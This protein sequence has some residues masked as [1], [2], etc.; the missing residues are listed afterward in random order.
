MTDLIDSRVAKF[1][2][3]PTLTGRE[4]RCSVNI[5]GHGQ[6]NQIDL[7]GHTGSLQ[8]RVISDLN[9]DEIKC[10]HKRF[11]NFQPRT[12][13]HDRHTM[14]QSQLFSR[15]IVL[16]FEG[17]RERFFYRFEVHL[18][19][20]DPMI[21]R[22]RLIAQA[23]RLR[24]DVEGPRREL[25]YS[26][27]PSVPETVPEQT[28]F[29]PKLVDLLK[30]SSTLISDAA[31]FSMWESWAWIFQIVVPSLVLV[32]L[33]PWGQR[34]RRRRSER[35]EDLVVTGVAVGLPG[36]KP[37]AAD[38][39]ASLVR[40]ECRIERLEPASVEALLEKRVVQLKKATGQKVAVT[41]P[42]QTVA[43]AG[44]LGRIDLD[45]YGVPKALAKTM[46]KASQAAVAA[47]LEALADAG[48]VGADWKL[49]SELQAST[50]VVYATSFPGLDAAV[51]E[52]ERYA[53]SL[54]KSNADL[55]SVLGDRL[56]DLDKD[57]ASDAKK[58]LDQLAALLLKEDCRKNCHHPPCACENP[59]HPPNGDSHHSGGEKKETY[60]F[61]R[62]F[63]FKVLVLGNSQL[64]QIT[65][66]KGPNAQTNAACA[67][68]TQ[69]M[70][71]AEDWLRAG[72][73]DRVVVI[74]GDDAS[75]D[76]LLPWLGGG[77]NA[78]GA[79]SVAASPKEAA[80]PFDARRNGMVLGAGAVGLVLEKR[81]AARKKSTC[82]LVATSVSNS[83]FHGAAMDRHH[84]SLE[85]GKF[86]EMVER[87]HGVSRSRI[88]KYGIYLSHETGTHATPS[89]SCAANEIFALKQN[90]HPSDLKH[91]LL[92]NTKAYTG[93]P[94]GVGVEDAFAAYAL[95]TPN[96]TCPPLPSDTVLDTAFDFPL[97]LPIG[98]K[99]RSFDFALRFAAG[100][101]SH[102]AFA[103]YART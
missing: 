55:V 38:N 42:R 39:F 60:T 69:A 99:T 67:G 20:V 103:L 47:G 33:L 8:G 48:L 84:I 35:K 98:K 75:G 71:I 18:G 15:T 3:G 7:F 64:A 21:Q 87:D 82:R 46:G 81:S 65:G 24:D 91:L 51:A 5:G 100:F 40:G 97:N 41:S 2:A 26:D 89:S 68:T 80:R 94:M 14:Q 54:P 22:H 66:A 56:A 78:L 43:V 44:R 61:D 27:V 37:F 11:R 34:R 31:F 86:L 92:A 49:P 70:A 58:H 62:K 23:I 96:T 79:A 16:P 102:V 85:L 19:R 76:A 90:F 13:Q 1:K 88:A 36:S 6:R 29:K 50:G 72:R 10:P 45:K 57:K 30:V 83:A 9:S 4:D 77:F 93:H 59:P 53:S 25:H 73:C 101:G 28:Y 63:L 95:S 74:A 12:L 32:L 17:R 52:V